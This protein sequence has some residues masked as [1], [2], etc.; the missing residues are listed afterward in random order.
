MA[1]LSFLGSGDQ[2][3]DAG[4][5]CCIGI[6]VLKVEP[7]VRRLAC[8]LLWVRFDRKQ[9]EKGPESLSIGVAGC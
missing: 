9:S 3:V 5:D 4:I 8:Q 1:L 7:F 6:A 2:L